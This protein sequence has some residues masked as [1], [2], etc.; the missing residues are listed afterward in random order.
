MVFKKSVTCVGPIVFVPFQYQTISVKVSIIK[1]PVG[2][3]LQ[4]N[5]EPCPG[6]HQTSV[7]AKPLLEAD[8]LSSDQIDQIL[9]IPA[10]EKKDAITTSYQNFTRCLSDLKAA[11]GKVAVDH[12]KFLEELKIDVSHKLIPENIKL[13]NDMKSIIGIQNHHSPPETKST[14]RMSRTQ[15]MPIKQ[16]FVQLSWRRPRISHFL[17]ILEILRH[18]KGNLKKLLCPIVILT[19]YP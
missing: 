14:S 15:S 10:N 5:P 12:T 8:D 11:S 7:D 4:L 9:L 16:E 18:L 19:K 13:R 1:F 6:N 3:K 2:G 17:E